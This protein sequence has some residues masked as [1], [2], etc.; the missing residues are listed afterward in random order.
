MSDLRKVHPGD[1]LQIPA[2]TYNAFVD[3]ARDYRDRTAGLERDPERFKAQ[4]GIVLVRNDTGAPQA[5]FAVLG[6]AA[7][8]VTPAD[9][10]LEFKGRVALSCVVPTDE[11]MGRFVILFEPIPAGEM[12]RAYVAGVCPVR[13][14]VTSADADRKRTDV[15]AGQTGVLS[16]TDSGSAAILWREDVGSGEAWALIRLDGGAASSLNFSFQCRLSSRVLEGGGSQPTVVVAQGYRQ[17]IGGLRESVP[18]IVLDVTGTGSVYMV[19]TYTTLNTPGSWGNL[20]YGTAPGD[21]ATQRVVVIATIADGVLIQ[22]HLGDVVV[23]DIVDRTVC[24]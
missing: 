4:S 17:A 7:P 15:T 22:R 12:G 14:T 19:W 16:L 8:V 11:H 6:I 23:L 9:N 3:A 1:R 2:A 24:A 10:E 5:Q 21:D 20:S 13:V 18:E